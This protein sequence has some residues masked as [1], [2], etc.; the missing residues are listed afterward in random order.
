MPFILICG[1]PSSGKSTYALELARHFQE[2][3]VVVIN[4]ENLMLVKNK[5]YSTYQEEKMMRG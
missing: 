3:E 4:E 2:R 5:V 1:P